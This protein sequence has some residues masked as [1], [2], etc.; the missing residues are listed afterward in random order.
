MLCPILELDLE[1]TE[2]SMSSQAFRFVDV[3]VECLERLYIDLE[4][5]F[6]VLSTRLYRWIGPSTCYSLP[7][8]HC[9]HR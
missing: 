6:E 9:K 2:G 5:A 7:P 1:L 3:C 8:V 4:L